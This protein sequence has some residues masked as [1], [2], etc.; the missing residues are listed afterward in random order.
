MLLTEI[1]VHKDT[2][3]AVLVLINIASFCLCVYDKKAAVSKGARVPER[4]LLALS[5]FFGSAGMLAGMYIFRH[6]TQKPLFFVT[7]PLMFVIHGILLY[8]AEIIS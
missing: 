3:I 7:V 2:I 5:L 6:K 8:A 4:V 1:F